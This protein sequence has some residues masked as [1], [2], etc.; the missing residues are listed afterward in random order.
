MKFFLHY[1]TSSA[2]ILL[3]RPP[4]Q[5][6]VDRSQQIEKKNNV[7]F[8]CLSVPVGELLSK[9]RN[10][11]R[12]RLNVLCVIKKVACFLMLINVFCLNK[13]NDTVIRLL[14]EGRNR[15]GPQ[16]SVFYNYLVLSFVSEFLTFCYCLLDFIEPLKGI[17]FENQNKINSLMS[18]AMR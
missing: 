10:S 2:F 8:V 1:L 6:N 18:S 15:I 16:T 17:Q 9:S 11:F 5:Y 13:W 12:N 7:I 14:S 3:K 4:T